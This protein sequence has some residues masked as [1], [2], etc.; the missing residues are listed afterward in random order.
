MSTSSVPKALYQANIDLALRIAALLQEQG[1]QWF[2]LFA[3]EAGVRLKQGLAGM[4]R[5]RRDFSI[6]TLPQMPVDL[7][8]HFNALDA[9]RWQ[10]LLAKAIEH[11]SR[12]SVGVQSALDDWQ[13]ACSQLLGEAL[14]QGVSP[15]FARAAAAVPGLG[16]MFSSLQQMAVKAGR[17]I[18][19]T[20][21]APDAD[22]PARKAAKPPAV[23]PAAAAKARAVKA[24]SKPVEKAPAKPSEKAPSKSA[25]KSA[26][27]PDARPAGASKAGSAAPATSGGKGSAA[28]FP[29]PVPALVTTPR[30]R[31]RP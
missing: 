7:S 30:Q 28:R 24:P 11:Q 18:V 22:T 31:K 12:F 26:K 16:E 9:E 10:A 20:A 8:D 13:G 2:D 14:P 15:G 3:D 27:K 29:S 21:A 25:K 5:F 6:D 23:K 4:D 17:G 1:Q 19:P